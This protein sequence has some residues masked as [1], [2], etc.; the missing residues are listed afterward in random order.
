[1]IGNGLAWFFAWLFARA[2]C[3]KALSPGYY[4]TITSRYAGAAG[5]A[6]VWPLALAEA[7]TALALLVPQWRLAGLACA[8]ALLLLYAGLMALQILR[9]KAAMECGCSGPGSPLQVSW[10]LVLRNGIC[11]GLALLAMSS[12]GSAVS[13]W[14]ATLVSVT[15]AVGAALA[16][17]AGEAIIANAQW[18]EG[19]D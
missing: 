18:M 12:A 16:Y 10:V 4:R 1:M 19:E 11:A 6:L 2:A 15:L 13:G 17:L 14:W 9:G 5:I 8:I 7:A 3:H